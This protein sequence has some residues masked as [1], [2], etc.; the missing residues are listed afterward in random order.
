[1]AEVAQTQVRG[2][3]DALAADRARQQRSPQH[4][5]GG[6]PKQN[7]SGSDRATWWMAQPTMALL[8]NRGALDPLGRQ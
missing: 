3:I 1:M 6:R 2:V 8:S 4:A 7:A 5:V